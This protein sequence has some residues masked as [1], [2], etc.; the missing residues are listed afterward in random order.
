MATPDT[1][2]SAGR[3]ERARAA[4]TGLAERVLAIPIVVTLNKTM[5]TFGGA[6]GGL[7][8]AALAYR[9]LMTLLPGFLLF[10]GLLGIFISDPERQ[11]EI[12]RQVSEQIPLLEGIIGQGIDAIVAG[13]GAASIIGLIGLAWG[14]SGFYG[15][16]DVAFARIFRSAPERSMFD[17]I[18]RGL[19]TVVCLLA[20]FVGLAGLAAVQQYVDGN[21]PEGPPGDAARTVLRIGVP[22]FSAVVITLIVAGVYRV[23]PNVRVPVRALLLPAILVGL[24]FAVMTQ[25][26]VYIAP[27]LVGGLA[28]FGSFGAVFAAL[29]WLSLGFQA[30]LLGASWTRERMHAADPASVPPTPAELGQDPERAAATGTVEAAGPGAVDATGEPAGPIELREPLPPPPPGVPPAPRPESDE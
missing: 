5:A 29:A 7:L 9:A 6:A 10:A 25:L 27:R 23:V 11:A 2:R 18:L 3:V 30:L 1:A 26:F 16:V 14:T 12:I 17:R 22:L 8:S 21:L 19:L 24:A 15:A 28:I 4:V 13:A 20:V